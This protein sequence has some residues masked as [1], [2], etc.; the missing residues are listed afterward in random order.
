ME[1]G[2]IKIS[3]NSHGNAFLA[4]V[5]G[6]LQKLMLGHNIEFLIDHET[7]LGELADVLRNIAEVI[8]SGKSFIKKE[9]SEDEEG[10]DPKDH[11]PFYSKGDDNDSSDW[12]KPKQ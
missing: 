8:D 9:I 1:N 6:V 3:S 10:F 5:Y 7:P 2:K 4:D 12:W 11:G